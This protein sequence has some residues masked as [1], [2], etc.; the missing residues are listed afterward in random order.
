MAVHQY[1]QIR[2]TDHFRLLQVAAGVYAALEKEGS[3]TGSNA[4]F[5]DMGEQVVVYDTFLSLDAAVE[6]RDAIRQICGRDPAYVINSHMHL[7]HV[8]GNQVFD[9]R[10]VVVT[11]ARVREA[12][13]TDTA[14]ALGSMQTHDPSVI[15]YLERAIR[16]EQDLAKLAN[17]KNS[18]KFLRNV[19]RPDLQLRYPELTFEHELTIHGAHDELRL[20]SL[21]VAH[22]P[23]D[24][25]GY[26]PTAKVCLAGDL[27]FT[28]E[29]PWIGAGNPLEYLKAWER[30]IELDADCYISGHGP[31]ATKDDIRLQIRYLNELLSLAKQRLA[32]GER[33][34]ARRD[35][36]PEFQ[37]WGGP[38]FQWNIDW[39]FGWL[40]SE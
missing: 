1:Q 36:S 9:R 8:V 33:A 34:I 16:E 35:F 11:S 31:L 3:D 29:P 5:A 20:T 13:L 26:L 15:A 27:I 2:E 24:V 6:L 21:S 14:K 12:M 22:S 28:S 37:A 39:I 17:H 23:G 38:V 10:T 32:A 4:A 30:L 19:L 25:F 7:D 18:L 40:S